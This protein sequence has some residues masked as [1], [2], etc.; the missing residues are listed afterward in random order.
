M[1]FSNMRNSWGVIGCGW[2][3]L[4]FA[5]HLINKGDKVIGTTTSKDKIELLKNAGISPVLLPSANNSKPNNIFNDC[6]YALLNIPPSSLKEK[7]ADEMLRLCSLFNSESQIIF[8]SSVSVYADKNQTVTENDNLDG[9]SRNAP[10][11]VEAE[12]KLQQSLKERLTIIRMAGLIG[13]GRHPVK[14]MSGKN[15]ENGKDKVNLIH[16]DDCIGLIK[17]V[18]E[19]NYFGETINGCSTEHP[20]K[21]DYYT[22]AAHKM[23]IIPPTFDDKE[24]KWKKVSNDKSK[25]S[26][27]YNY[28]YESPYDFPI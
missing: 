28:K 2:L 21:M 7:Y 14:Y 27:N 4:P 1:N 20:K 26:L 11:I 5:K 17:K 22:W 10:Y 25:N 18:V 23:N 13:A 16:L 19:Q 6:N 24:G 15:Y 3:G 8:I 9:D 12:K